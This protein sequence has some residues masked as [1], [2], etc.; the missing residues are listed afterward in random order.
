MYIDRR[1]SR[2]VFEEMLR[3]YTAKRKPFTNLTS[4]RPQDHL[5]PSLQNDELGQARF[6]FFLCLYM[7]GGIDSVTAT[8][9]LARAYEEKRWLFENEVL[10]R[11]AEEIQTMLGG[12]IPL[13]KNRIG[14]FWRN[15]AEVLWRYWEGDP[16]KIFSPTPSDE[17]EVYY[18]LMGKYYKPRTKQLRKEAR[19]QLPGTLAGTIYDYQVYTG[20]TGFREK[21][22]S[23]L[24]YFL[25]DSGLIT[26]PPPLSAPVD[27]HHLRI[28]LQ[29][30]MIVVEG[31]EGR[32]RYERLARL[33]RELAAYLQIHFKLPMSVYGDILWLW[34]KNLCSQAPQNA[35]KADETK[36]QR[37]VW[38]RDKAFR[39]KPWKDSE[40]A[41]YERSCVV[42]AIRT[43][44]KLSV[45][46]GHYYSLGHLRFDPQYFPVGFQGNLDFS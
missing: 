19:Q 10:S 22:T 21:M 4:D 30:K 18:R 14:G 38:E 25:Y 40:R 28:Y 46:S 2:V 20:F 15:N 39:Q 17:H 29:T 27:F 36:T 6:Y 5:P 43:Y 11:S 42:C 33:G 32:V 45:P 9:K 8:K 7:R 13:F 44:C 23:M 16:R 31:I 37:K 41:A 26:K 35:S 3:Q 12:Y 1:Q 24:A 34:S